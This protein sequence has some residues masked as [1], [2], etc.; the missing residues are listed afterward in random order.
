MP[1]ATEEQREKHAEGNK[2]D[3]VAEQ[4]VFR[5]F[6]I[7]PPVSVIHIDGMEGCRIRFFHPFWQSNV[8]IRC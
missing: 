4:V 1:H 8:C 5:V 7:D 6:R 2:T 3:Q